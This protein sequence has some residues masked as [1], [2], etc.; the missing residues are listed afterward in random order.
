MVAVVVL[1]AEQRGRLA[2]GVPPAFCLL[3]GMPLVA[4]AA[5]ELPAPPSGCGAPSTAAYLGTAGS[6]STG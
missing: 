2:A 5:G 4:R 1:A 3:D 6:S